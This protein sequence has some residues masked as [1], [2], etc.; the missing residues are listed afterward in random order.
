MAERYAI[1]DSRIRVLSTDRLLDVMGSQ[2]SAFRQV[3]PKAGYCKMA[4]A[5]DWLFRDCLRQMVDLAET[6][7]TVGIVGAYRLD[8]VRVDLDGLPYPSTVVLGKELLYP[9]RFPGHS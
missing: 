2:N 3:S 7:P 5:D 8:G 6:H 1:K 9:T 4:H